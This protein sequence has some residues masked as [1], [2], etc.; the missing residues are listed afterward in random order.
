MSAIPN[1]HR[2]LAAPETTGRDVSFAERG[3][4]FLHQVGGGALC[5]VSS[6][7]QVRS[8]L[9]VDRLFAAMDAVVAGHDVLRTGYTLRDGEL[10]AEVS[11]QVIVEKTA[12]DAAGAGTAEIARWVE[13]E[14][15]RPFTM[16][17][18]GLSRMKVWTRGPEDHVVLTTMHHAAVDWTAMI[19]WAEQLAAHYLFGGAGAPAEGG[20]YAEFV[21]SQRAMLAGPDGHEAARYWRT[22]L[23]AVR[24]EPPVPTGAARTGPAVRQGL[25][26]FALE[27]EVKRRVERAAWKAGVPAN[28]VLLALWLLALHAEDGR[29]TMIVGLPRSLRRRRYAR[30]IGCF[31]NTMPLVA[32]L[33]GGPSAA[34]LTARLRARMTESVPHQAYP[35]ELVVQNTP[36]LGAVHG[37]PPVYDVTFN[38]VPGDAARIAPLTIGAQP[39]MET[40][41]GGLRLAA[42][43]APPSIGPTADFSLHL[44]EFPGRLVGL[45]GYDADLFERET[46]ARLCRSV[47]KA[48]AEI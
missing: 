2:D 17:D 45:V 33:S 4:W 39:E 27:G 21:A 15:A 38:Y 14:H 24:P 30:T 3:L 9:D 22:A 41:L 8:P 20:T 29:E 13:A 18:H 26:P 48:A 42:F 40:E 36:D 43:P 5:N 25:V 23:P 32:D 46:A 34:E 10:R 28:I 19:V 12:E 1:S 37:R 7:I 6:A 11:P 16:S 47:Q 44:T 31:T 35:F